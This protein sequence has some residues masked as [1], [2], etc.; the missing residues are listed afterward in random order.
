VAWTAPP[1]PAEWAAALRCVR[2]QQ[3][4]LF[5]VD[6]G[7]D[8]ADAFLR[9]LAGLAKHALQAYGGRLAWE[10]L[11]AGIGQR[12]VTVQAGVR[13]LAALGVCTIVE[14]WGD[15][16]AVASGGLRDPEQESAARSTVEA[17]LR[18]TAAYRR[19]FREADSRKLVA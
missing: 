14:E 11:A 15:A 18:E 2:A 8:A 12:I 10:A 9:R 13:W 17:L 5:A 16:V 6:A 19:Y 3:V 4:Y 1:G 7:L